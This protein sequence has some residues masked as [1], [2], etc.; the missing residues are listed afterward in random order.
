MSVA[1]LRRFPSPAPA[2]GREWRG[3]LVYGRSVVETITVA[4][5]RTPAFDLFDTEVLLGGAVVI[6]ILA[7][8]VLKNLRRERQQMQAEPKH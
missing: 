2:A 8:V 1:E 6:A 7:W 5:S 4:A 3:V